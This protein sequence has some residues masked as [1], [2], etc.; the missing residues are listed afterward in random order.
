[1]SLLCQMPFLFESTYSSI[2]MALTSNLPNNEC[3]LLKRLLLMTNQ[4]NTGS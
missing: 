3:D 2:L 1:M 4:K